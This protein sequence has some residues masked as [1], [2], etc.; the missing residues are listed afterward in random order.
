[1]GAVVRAY[2][3][4]PACREQVESV[5]A[6][7]VQLELDTQ[8]AEGKGGYASA[9]GEEFY[10][11]QRELMGQVVA[12]SDVVVTTAA[13]P[14]KPSPLLITRDAVERM[15]PG[16]VII[17]LA[18]ERGGNCELTQPDQRVVHQDV[19]I[20]GPTNLPSDT[21]YHASQMFSNNVT[22]FLLNMIADGHVR[23]NQDDPIVSETLVAADGRVTSGRLRELLGLQP[24]HDASPVASDPSTLGSAQASEPSSDQAGPPPENAP[25]ES[26]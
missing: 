4:R 14:G 3:V 1:L 10:R 19:T 9:M 23:L 12:E 8:Q 18:A 17:D 13:I 24:L 26:S 7:F 25:K 16:S 6:K 11:R 20:L 21:P 2:D 15:A 5:G 22:Q